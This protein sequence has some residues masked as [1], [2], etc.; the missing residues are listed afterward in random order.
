[1][2]PNSPGMTVLSRRRWRSHPTPA[3]QPTRFL[4]GGEGCSAK[5]HGRMG[6][7]TIKVPDAPWRSEAPTRAEHQEA[8]S[9]NRSE[10]LVP[11]YHILGLVA[12][13]GMGFVYAAIALETER[14]VAL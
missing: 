12:E 8:P 9:S 5:D 13:G 14:K 11:G 1:P 10:P 2:R 4:P 7:K 6:S 3:A